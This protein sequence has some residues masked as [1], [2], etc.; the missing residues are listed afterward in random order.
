MPPFDVRLMAGLVDVDVRIEGQARSADEKFRQLQFNAA[1]A[2]I[3]HARE[4]GRP[5]R[6]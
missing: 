3:C 2:S 4:C 6:L 1:G 5:A